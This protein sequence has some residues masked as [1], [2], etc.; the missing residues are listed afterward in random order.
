[1]TN[2][3]GLSARRLEALTDLSW[4]GCV[5]SGGRATRVPPAVAAA[6][7]GLPPLEDDI[8]SAER[9]YKAGDASYLFVL[10]TTRRLTDAR[11]RDA[12]LQ[13]A[14]ARAFIALER[15]VGRRLIANR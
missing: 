2:S 9:A 7:G 10:E 6:L 12:E 11:L 15:S 1:M 5:G 3:S 13:V 8:R 4:L 14:T